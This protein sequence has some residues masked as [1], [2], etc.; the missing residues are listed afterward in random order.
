MKSFNIEPFHFGVED[1]NKMQPD[2]S[3][4]LLNQNPVENKYCFGVMLDD[5][6]V[7]GSPVCQNEAEFVINKSLLKPCVIINESWLLPLAIT[8]YSELDQSQIKVSANYVNIKISPF[9][10]PIL[11]FKS[12]CSLNLKDVFKKEK[13]IKC[14]EVI[15]LVKPTCALLT[16]C[17]YLFRFSMDYDEWLYCAKNPKTVRSKIMLAKQKVVE[18]LFIPKS[19]LINNLPSIFEMNELKVRIL[20]Q[21]LINKNLANCF[22]SKRIQNYFY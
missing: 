8:I 11:L 4:I 1:I 6:S 22:S 17:W 9:K 12:S 15:N 16:L 13:D 14:C 5:T 20:G 3:S 7:Y 2:L 19:Y 18:G 10:K 21:N